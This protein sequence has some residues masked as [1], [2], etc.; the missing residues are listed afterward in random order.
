[1]QILDR[2]VITAIDRCRWFRG[3]LSG[4][5]DIEG[6]WVDAIVDPANPD[7]IVNVEYCRIRFQQ[8]KYILSGDLWT[9]EGKWIDNF[10]TT[11]GASYMGRELE[12][13]YKS[14]IPGRPM[15]LA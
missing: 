5:D 11:G 13:Y 12:Y 6:D 14:G 3:I 9:A 8:G 1:M 15:D 7:R 4:R 10:V 2:A